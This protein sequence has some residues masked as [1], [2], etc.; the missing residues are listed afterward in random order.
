M[1]RVFIL[2]AGGFVGTWLR[3]ELADRDGVTI[4]PE[5]PAD[6]VDV[7]DESGLADLLQRRPDVLVNLAAIA[8]PREAEHQPALTD[9]VNHRGA[10]AV[11]RAILAHAP[12]CRLIH[13]G[14]AVAYGETFRSGR[15]VDE[16]S[17]LQPR[18][19]YGTS[20]ALADAEIATLAEAGLNVVRLRPFWHAGPGQ[21]AGYVVP[22]FAGQIARIMRGELPPRVAVGN[23]EVYRDFLDVRDVARLYADLAT[24]E[25]RPPGDVYNIA[26]GVPTSI[27][28]LL[29]GLIARSGRA[30]TVEVDPHRLRPDEVQRAV[31]DPRLAARDLGWAPRH[32][33]ERMLDDVLAEWL[34]RPTA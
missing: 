2:G 29:D 16:E 21:Q 4:W 1:R 23:L 27:R 7:R 5:T 10:V 28:S 24:A 14:S 8:S 11:A 26:S 3:R 32:T 9:A 19:A 33:V 20:K 12:E 25:N 22:S 34:A 17:P 13:V 18:G 6:F 30:I 15:P 31:G